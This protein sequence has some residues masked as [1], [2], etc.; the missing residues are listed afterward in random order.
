MFISRSGASLNAIY[1]M[2]SQGKPESVVKSNP[3]GVALSDVQEQAISNSKFF[4]AGASMSLLNQPGNIG[5][6]FDQHALALAIL[7]RLGLSEQSQAGRI[8]VHFQGR[9]QD[10]R[11]VLEA[12]IKPLSAQSD[13]IG[14][15]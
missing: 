9:E 12:S 6:V 7:L 10:L 8:P 3:Q 2:D 13:Q 4:E 1:G 14:R 5:D 15:R 11:D